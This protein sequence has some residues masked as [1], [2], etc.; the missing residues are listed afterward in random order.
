MNYAL[1]IGSILGLTGILL[2]AF[3]DHSLQATLSTDDLNS[4]QVALKYHHLYAIVILVLAAF[5]WLPISE[6]LAGL[7]WI[8]NLFTVAVIL[9]SGS[10][11][12]RILTGYEDF[13]WLTPLGGSLLIASWASLLIAGILWK[14]KG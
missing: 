2:G 8:I 1:V 5:K 10:I 3:G 14:K 6:R 4:W 11:Y 13:R 12:I 7:D 9:F